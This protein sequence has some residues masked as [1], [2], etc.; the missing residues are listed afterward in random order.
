MTVGELRKVLEGVPD[1]LTVL[2][3]NDG[4]YQ[5]S[6]DARASTSPARAKTGAIFSFSFPRA[7]KAAVPTVNHIRLY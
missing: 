5:D 2:I 1:D 4:S 3:G 6:G 7:L